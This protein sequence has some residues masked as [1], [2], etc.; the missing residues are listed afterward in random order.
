MKGTP[1]KMNRFMH[2]YLSIALIV[3]SAMYIIIRIV[4][5]IPY[6][7][8]LAIFSPEFFI[9]I[10]STTFLIM[11]EVKKKDGNSE[12]F[13]NRLNRFSLL[14]IIIAFLL[15]LTLYASAINLYAYLD[16]STTFT[17]YCYALL[18]S[19]IVVYALFRNKTN[20]WV[21]D[22]ETSSRKRDIF[23][24][25]VKMLS[26]ISL[27]FLISLI[28]SLFIGGF[29]DT[30]FIF[31]NYMVA[32]LLILIPIALIL[33]S[34]SI[35]EFVITTQSKVILETVPFLSKTALILIIIAFVLRLFNTYITDANLINQMHSIMY[36]PTPV[37]SMN[38]YILAY[39]FAI[40]FEIMIFLFVYLSIR[41]W[42]SNKGLMTLL[43]VIYSTVR[44]AFQSVML[45]IYVSFV[46]TYQYNISVD[47]VTT[48][49]YIFFSIMS[50]L[51][52]GLLYYFYK[53]KLPGILELMFI[54][55]AKL[56]KYTFLRLF[57]D[58]VYDISISYFTMILTEAISTVLIIIIGL[59]LH[60]LK[61]S[62]VSKELSI[63]EDTIKGSVPQSN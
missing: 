29:L 7:F 8:P 49:Q 21:F 24:K 19:F 45:S 34:I 25:L 12:E 61:M 41:K 60:R 13:L 5:Q 51:F 27:W 32:Y 56:Y 1:M 37:P 36:L 10:L 31:G 30:D 33:T 58:Y 44:V 55:I 39:S 14:V 28:L 40:F 43:L 17:L 16:T 26:K 54:L 46:R 9:L 18:I 11:S 3:I 57:Q 53:N 2:R 23:F 15:S 6:L 20:Y 4:F 52:L 59:K 38:Y 63:K 22:F 42:L 62:N 35:F 50:A 47:A 48:I